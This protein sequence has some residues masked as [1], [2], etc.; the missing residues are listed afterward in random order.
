MEQLPVAEQ[1]DPPRFNGVE[2]SYGVAPI[3]QTLSQLSAMRNRPA[4]DLYLINVETIIRDRRD[5]RPDQQNIKNIMSDC[6]VLANYLYNYSRLT[7]KDI[8][9]LHPIC[10]FYMGYYE[11]LPKFHLKDKLPKGTEE[12]WAIRDY[13]SQYLRSNHWK[14]DYENFKVLFAIPGLRNPWPHKELLNDINQFQS[15]IRFRKCLMI[16]HVAA[17]FHTYKSVA[18]FHI[19]ESYTGRIKGVKDLGEKVFKDPN[20]PFNKY[21]HLT[22]GDKTYVKKLVTP[23]QKNHLAELAKRDRWNLL[24]EKS[25]LAAIVNTGYVSAKTF[26]DSQL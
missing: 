16:S 10:C 21:T 19:L 25:I 11:N 23:K 6:E 9:K 18:E 4:W 1:M 15:G 7:L 3:M 22:L 12:R 5:L 26:L 8:V 24:P 2:V 14:D 20:I 17:D 13:L